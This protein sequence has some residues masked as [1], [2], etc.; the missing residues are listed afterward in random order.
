MLTAEIKDGGDREG[1]TQGVS[2]HDG[3]RFARRV[4]GLQLLCADVSSGR[5]VIDKHGNGSGLDNRRN[6]GRK[7]CGDGDHFV[8]G[9]DAFVRRQ[10]VGGERGEGHEI[11]RGAGIDEQGVAD[12]KKRGEFFLEGLAL[13]AKREP[14]IQSGRDGS[15]HFVFVE[16]ATGVRNSGFARNKSRTLRIVARS[17]GGMKCAG[18]GAGGFANSLFENGSH[19]SHV[20]LTAI[21]RNRGGI[22]FSH[23][24]D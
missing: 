7:P 11:G 24:V 8:A 15:L 4:C 2:Y 13:G 10:L 12:A 17:V 5:V 9:L 19:E 18:V 22:G 23:I 14:E 6:G 3:L 16:D 1:I 20:Q 21:P